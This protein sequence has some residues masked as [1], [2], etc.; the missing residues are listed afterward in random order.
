[1]TWQNL[2]LVGGGVGVGIVLA[3]AWRRATRR[4][5]IGEGAGPTRGPQTPADPFPKPQWPNGHV[6]KQQITLL[7]LV[8][9]SFGGTQAEVLNKQVRF[10]KQCPVCSQK[11]RYPLGVNR[12]ICGRCK[13]PLHI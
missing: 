4:Q 1:M 6:V 10:V 5:D 2:L 11:N 3:I 9:G 13:S 7:D 8:M 12:P